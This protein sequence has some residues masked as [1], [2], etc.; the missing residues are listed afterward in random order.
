L[1]LFGFAYRRNLH[2]EHFHKQ[3]NI[4]L[5]TPNH[6]DWFNMITSQGKTFSADPVNAA[7]Y[8]PF[9]ARKPLSISGAFVGTCLQ[10]G[11]GI[12]VDPPGLMNDGVINGQIGKAT[13]P[14]GG[15]KSSLMKSVFG[16]RLAAVQDGHIVYKDDDGTIV[17]IPKKARVLADDRKPNLPEIA[18]GKSAEGEWIP[19]GRFVGATIVELASLPAINIFHP[20]MGFKEQHL[21]SLAIKVAELVGGERLT[22]YERFVLLIGVNLMYRH[23]EYRKVASV[24]TLERI[25]NKMTLEH[26]SYYYKERDRKYLASHAKRLRYDLELKAALKALTADDPQNRRNVELQDDGRKFISTA[27]DLAVIFANAQQGQ[28]GEVI[29]EEHS[30]FDILHARRAIWD[31]TNITKEA[32]AI[33]E[34]VRGL[35]QEASLYRPEL[36]ITPTIKLGDEER[37]AGDSLIH[38]EHRLELVEKARAFGTCEITSEQ[39]VHGMATTLGDKDSKQRGIVDLINKGTAMRFYGTQPNDDDHLDRISKESN[40]ADHEVHQLTL[41]GPGEWAVQAGDSKA[42]WARHELTEHEWPLV[43]TNAA[44]RRQ[45]QRIPLGETEYTP[46]VISNAR[47]RR[48]IANRETMQI[49]MD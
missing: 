10:S 37:S 7:L 34:T 19:Y 6:G 21:H 26:L 20:D 2:L 32:R 28:F 33:L 14:R 45:V 27:A 12:W 30:I 13:A 42:V 31:W 48:M 11:R 25:L 35:A 49:G 41:L 40:L 29:G 38:L 8:L 23:K 3:L 16:I 36:D 1:R 9:K 15:A 43:E 17:R 5:H 46:S 22:G 18:E 47:L 24:G 44:V 4:L 39:W